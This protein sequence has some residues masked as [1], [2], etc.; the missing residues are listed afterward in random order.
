MLQDTMRAGV[1][2][3][4]VMKKTKEIKEKIK[5]RIN[6]DVMTHMKKD[7]PDFD[8]E[9]MEKEMQYIFELC[10]NSYLNHDIDTI[11]HT[12]ISEG[13]SFFRQLIESQKSLNQVHKYKNI[14]SLSVPQLENAI[15]V[16]KKFP[17]FVFSLRFHE[18]FCLINPLEPETII[19][20]SNSNK[21]L[22]EMLI[23]VMPHPEPEVEKSGH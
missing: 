21:V 13:L 15:M 19:E 1:D 22:N 11:S 8:L 17:L 16:K 2:N 18:L 7:F 6:N 5:E 4:V 14:F 12:C 23:Y 3:S 20:G 9:M 10:Y